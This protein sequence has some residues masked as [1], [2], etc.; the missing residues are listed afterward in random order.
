MKVYEI[1]VDTF[2]SKYPFHSLHTPF[3]L[4]LLRP[5][6]TRLCR[7][8]QTL[9]RRKRKVLVK[10][11]RLFHWPFMAGLLRIQFFFWCRSH[12]GIGPS[13]EYWRFWSICRYTKVCGAICGSMKVYEV[14]GDPFCSKY[15]SLSLHTLC[16]LFLLRPPLTRSQTRK[17]R[18]RRTRRA[19]SAIRDYGAR[20][21]LIICVAIILSSCR[22]RAFIFLILDILKYM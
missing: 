17:R 14:Y 6:L 21:V 2:C 3:R 16:P 20:R 7:Q 19:W 22:N 18:T 11:I 10:K 8:E 9:K 15:P 5:P 12:V 1:Y 4:S 13:F